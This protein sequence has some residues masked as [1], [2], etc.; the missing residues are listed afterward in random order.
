MPEIKVTLISK[1]NKKFIKIKC[2]NCNT[3]L[4]RYVP[5]HQTGGKDRCGVCE[6]ELEWE[7]ING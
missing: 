4:E 6:A 3:L 5:V 1:P 7:V 2:P